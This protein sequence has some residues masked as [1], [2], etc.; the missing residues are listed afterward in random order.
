MKELI[1]ETAKLANIR[2]A[3]LHNIDLTKN[4]NQN[5]KTNKKTRIKKRK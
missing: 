1:I 3:Q 4:N 2:L 5:E